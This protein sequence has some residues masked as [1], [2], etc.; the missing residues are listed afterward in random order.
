M[1]L[2]VIEVERKLPENFIN[3]LYENYSPLTVQKILAGMAG[4]RN[5]TLRVNT[6]KNNVHS[7]MNNLKEN[8]I[9][10]ERVQWY[11]EALILKNAKEKKIQE[12]DIYI[13]LFT[14]FI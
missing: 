8:N 13:C 11:D 1:M 9:K 6:I 3:N 10:F 14:K 7:V 5:T 12:L 2:S 4:E